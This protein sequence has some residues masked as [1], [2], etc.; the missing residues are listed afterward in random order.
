ML[1]KISRG[2]GGQEKIRKQPSPLGICTI[3]Q[4]VRRCLRGFSS[5]KG[6]AVETTFSYPPAFAFFY[7]YYLFFWEQHRVKLNKVVS[8]LFT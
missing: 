1:Y 4:A 2:R 3:H 8:N 6:H 7:Y 5:L